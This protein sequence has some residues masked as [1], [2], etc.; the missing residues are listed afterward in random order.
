MEDIGGF[1]RI[2]RAVLHPLLKSI[3]FCG[4]G[5]RTLDHRFFILLDGGL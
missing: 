5:G 2:G 4:G 1:L 3:S